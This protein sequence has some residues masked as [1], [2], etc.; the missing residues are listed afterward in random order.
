MH[1]ATLARLGVVALAVVS[2]GALTACSRDDDIDLTAYVQDIEP[3]DVLYNQGLANLEAGK[4]A[5][6]SRKF[7][8]VIRQHPFTEFGRKAKVMAAFTKYRTGD[9]TGAIADARQYVSLYPSSEDSAYALYIIGLA[10]YRQIQDVTRDQRASRQTIA[11]M[12][13]VVDRFPDSEYVEDANAKIRFARDQLAGKEMQVGRYYQERKEFV[14]SISRFRTV[15]QEYS[16]TRH[17]EEALARLVESY[18]AMGLTSE[19][20]TAAAILGNNYP[21]SQWYADSYALLQTGGLEPRESGN[22]WLSQAA[23]ALGGA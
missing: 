19:A 13:E 4:T 22:S 2:T 1:F 12:Q 6:A 8:A 21:D 7:D 14:A 10:N 16:N 18:F 9:Y 15:V 5:E 3:A 23:R 11:A 20:Q 17:I